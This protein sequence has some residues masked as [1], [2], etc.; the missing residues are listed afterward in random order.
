MIYSNRSTLSIIHE[1]EVR[2]CS[3]DH[4]IFLSALKHAHRSCLCCSF[5]H[6]QAW[7]IIV[8]VQIFCDGLIRSCFF[9]GCCTNAFVIDPCSY[10]SLNF[11]FSLRLLGTGNIVGEGYDSQQKKA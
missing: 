4:L 7:F 10:S 2:T 9:A 5:I 1:E 3:V 11:F 6:S 8:H